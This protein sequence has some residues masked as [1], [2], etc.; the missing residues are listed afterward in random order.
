MVRPGVIP[1]QIPMQK[2]LFDKIVALL[3]PEMDDA[4]ARKSIVESALIG[5][6]VLEKI[7]WEGAVGTFTIR[8]VR[9]LHEF[10]QIT[11][12]RSALAALLEEVKEQVGLDRQAEVDQ[13]LAQ[14]EALPPK[15]EIQP[16]SK[17]LPESL[18]VES[19]AMPES[20]QA[21]LDKVRCGESNVALSPDEADTIKNH[22]PADLTQFRLCRIAAGEALGTLGD[23]RF[24]RQT[25]PH[26][27]YL[28]PPLVEI[29]GGK[30]PMGIDKSDY[31]DEKPAHTVELES[32]QIGQFPVTNAEYKCFLE[33]GGYE[34]ERWWD[35]EESRAWLKGEASTEGS[36][37][38]WRDNRK[39]F[40][41][42]TEDYIRGLVTQNRI[43][44]KQSEDWITIR[45]WTDE[46]FEQQLDEWFPAGKTYRQPEYWDDTRF[47]NP[48]QPV[49][50]VTWF[51]AR[52][53]CNWMT[54]NAAMKD[55]LFRLPTE[56][57]FEA[58]AHGA[59]GRMFPYGNKFDVARS[60]TFESHIRRT[61]PVG[62]FDNSTPE[63]A[64]DLSGN[65]Y[66]W[67]LSIYDQQQFP[68]PYKKD[69]GRENIHQP[70]VNRVLRGG[71]WY[72]DRD[73]ARAVYRDSNNPGA[74]AYSIGFRV[75]SWMR[76]PSQ[77]GFSDH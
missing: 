58:V 69:D 64:F 61:T 45:N 73:G 3:V 19:R 1:D 17:V 57:E 11:P 25:G 2:D 7:L 9:Q 4:G 29:P 63:G 44:S 41:S 48:S 60:N 72:D 59:K 35:T 28:L 70:G 40:Q 13:I 50:G 68:Y 65:A 6:P 74:R 34:D 18:K 51:E 39:S 49:V 77:K 43:T 30:Y 5:S 8:L 33:A 20:L 47:N 32:F 52:A 46:R 42:W 37:E 22:K 23:P 76:P 16:P 54:A 15:Q 67:T 26:G 53:Y 71:S 24:V 55:R 38:R 36:K 31:D 62:V 12:G 56:A 66:T 10:G 75:V 21:L 14:L 27:K